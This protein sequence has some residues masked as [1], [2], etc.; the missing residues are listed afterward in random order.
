MSTPLW[1]MPALIA[2]MDARPVGDLPQS[3]TGISIDT[4]T[5]EPGEAFFAIKGEQFDG[6]NFLM[7]ATKAGAAL[8]VVSEQK[9]PALG[10]V[11]APLL[12]VDDVLKALTRLAEAARARS[13]ATIIA[14]TG[15][16]G[17]TTTKEALRHGLSACGS[18]HAS[19]ASFNNHWGVPLSLARLP[20][21]ARFAVFE[22][23]MNHPGEIRPLVK[24]VRPDLAIVTLIAPAHLGHFR[25][26][27]EIADAKAEI[28]EGLVE[29]GTAILNGDDAQ[30]GRLATMAR[31]AG[32]SRIA[33][34]GEA[35][36][37][38]FR[39]TGFAPS[40]EGAT[41]TATIAGEEVRVELAP[42]GRHMA[43]NVLAVLGAAKLAGADVQAVASALGSWRAVKGRGARH[44]LPLKEGGTIT[45]I[46]DSYNANPASMR[47][48]LDV[49]KTETPGE[50]G[51]RIA[52]IGDMLEL[53]THAAS[54]HADLAGAIE[55]AG[56]DRVYMAGDEM[57]ALDDVLENRVP[58]EWHDDVDELLA[59]LLGASRAGDVIMVKASKSIG[60]GPLVERIIAH[61]APAGDA[62]SPSSPTT[63]G[64]DA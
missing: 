4:R 11:L 53:G 18:V 63:S 13:Q 32:V 33:T 10:S 46:D 30:C 59:S 60:F 1:D 38:D 55:A 26:L 25:D 28:F 50:G 24:L 14:V 64:A 56:V 23:G 40:P 57:K 34:F 27:D 29:G 39:L 31:A 15:S 43:Q 36:G 47:A 35:A 52:V 51:R 20:A 21:D 44:R 2:A 62:A 17:K 12:V 3:I 41:V 54:L 5:L 58:R 48:A 49:L 9:L 22:I 6:H 8:H 45:L 42:S 19:A 37:T 16:V 61:H 7:A